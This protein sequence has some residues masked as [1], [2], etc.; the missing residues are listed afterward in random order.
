MGGTVWAPVRRYLKAFSGSIFFEVASE[1]GWKCVVVVNE[2]QG[3]DGMVCFGPVVED[4]PT[5]S[6]SSFNFLD[7][8]LDGFVSQRAES[9]RRHNDSFCQ[10]N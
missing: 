2:A 6:R 8:D 4:G 9:L 7:Q 1:P 10:V 3:N 5:Y